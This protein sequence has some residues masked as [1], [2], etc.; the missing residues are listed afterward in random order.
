MFDIVFVL[1][2]VFNQESYSSI[3]TLNLGESLEDSQSPSPKIWL[4]SFVILC[5]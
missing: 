2:Q 1:T 4:H 3:S 5:V